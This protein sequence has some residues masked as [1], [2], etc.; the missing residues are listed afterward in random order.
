ML[1]SF[2]DD[3]KSWKQNSHVQVTM[4]R[5]RQN[6]N[7]YSHITFAKK[8]LSRLWSTAQNME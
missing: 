4:I 2:D 8:L 7:S 3:I 6:D 1:K 5:N